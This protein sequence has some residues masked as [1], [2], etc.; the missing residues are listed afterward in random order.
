MLEVI[1]WVR[2]ALEALFRSWMTNLYFIFAPH[3]G[4]RCLH[5]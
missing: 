1:F 5:I 4:P 2:S 3:T